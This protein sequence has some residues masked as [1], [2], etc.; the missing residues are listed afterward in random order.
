M[1]HCD[2]L[3]LRP[4]RQLTATALMWTNRSL[5]EALKQCMHQQCALLQSHNLRKSAWTGLTL[6]KT[7]RPHHD[8]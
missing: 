7:A 1:L 4:L 3:L 5:G 6:G 2:C 8:V